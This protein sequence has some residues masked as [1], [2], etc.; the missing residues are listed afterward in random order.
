MNERETRAP[1]WYGALAN[2]EK[3]LHLAWAMLDPIATE[4]VLNG[5]LDLRPNAPVTRFERLGH[6]PQ[7]EDPAALAGVI[8][9]AL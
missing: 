7:I 4:N 6:Y 3:P 8:S 1:R 5:V 2:W 9:A